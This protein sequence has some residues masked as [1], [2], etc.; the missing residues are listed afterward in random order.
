MMANLTSLIHTGVPARYPK[1]KVVFTEAGISWV[2]YMMWRMDKYLQRVPPRGAIPGTSAGRLHARADVVR[3]PADRGTRRS[4]APGRDDHHI[5]DDRVIFAS[6]WP[7]HD[8]DHPKA[9]LKLPMSQ[10]LKRESWAKTR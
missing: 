8:F 4:L 9:I 5:G 10:E 7:H 6:D 3:H 2:P 1:L